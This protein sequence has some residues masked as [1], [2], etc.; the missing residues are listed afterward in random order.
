MLERSHYAD[1]ILTRL[2]ENKNNENRNK[3]LKRTN[4]KLKVVSGFVLSL[5]NP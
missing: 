2:L 5:T 3:V 1:F 4:W